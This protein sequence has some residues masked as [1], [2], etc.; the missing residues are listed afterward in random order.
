MFCYLDNFIHPTDWFRKNMFLM[1]KFY[2]PSQ[3]I[4]CC[5]VELVY[6]TNFSLLLEDRFL[7]HNFNI[8]EYLEGKGDKVVAPP[9]FNTIVNGVYKHDG[10]LSGY[11]DSRR[12]DG[13]AAVY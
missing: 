2:I 6:L 12:E 8:T 1:R 10:H 7:L 9:M 11:A 3:W 5:C 13:G 4:R